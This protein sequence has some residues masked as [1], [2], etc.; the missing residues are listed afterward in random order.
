MENGECNININVNTEE[1]DEEVKSN[2]FKQ[3]PH[4]TVMIVLATWIIFLWGSMS[5][6]ATISDSDISPSDERWWFLNIGEWPFCNDLKSQ[7]WRLLSM[8]FVHAGMLHIGKS[9]F[10]HK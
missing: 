7:G 4:F 8:Q 10:Y 6:Q 3:P 2:T 1:G 9:L 5:T